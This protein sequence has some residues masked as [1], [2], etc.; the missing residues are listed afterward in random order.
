V[1]YLLFAI[2]LWVAAFTVA[3]GLNKKR[4]LPYHTIHMFVYG[5]LLGFACLFWP[6]TL[7]V[8]LVIIVVKFGSDIVAAKK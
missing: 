2:L 7:P 5:L 1:D 4:Q 3:L 8:A 6:I